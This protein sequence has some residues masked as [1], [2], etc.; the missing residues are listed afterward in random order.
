[1]NSDDISTTVQETLKEVK[2]ALHDKTLTNEM[3]FKELE[4]DSL[5]K[6]DLFFRLE[7]KFSMSFSNK[8]KAKM[9]VIG[10]TVNYIQNHAK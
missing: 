5:D 8:E 7:E 9:K 2:F 4:V 6:M 1:M 3:S 10:D